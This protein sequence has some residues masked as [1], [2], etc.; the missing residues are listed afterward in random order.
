[1]IVSIFEQFIL[2]LDFEVA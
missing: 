1:M 2:N